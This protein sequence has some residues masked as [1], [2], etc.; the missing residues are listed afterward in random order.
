MAVGYPPFANV[1]VNQQPSRVLGRR[2]PG[3]GQIWGLR[4]YSTGGTAQYRLP[5]IWFQTA[6]FPGFQSLWSYALVTL[7]LVLGSLNLI[8]Q[9]AWLMC[10]CF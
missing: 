10:R 6:G 5:V 2:S 7:S 1:R 9:S 3:P 4:Q 8:V